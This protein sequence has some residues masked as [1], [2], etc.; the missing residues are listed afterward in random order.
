MGNRVFCSLVASWLLCGEDCTLHNCLVWLRHSCCFRICKTQDGLMTLLQHSCCLGKVGCSVLTQFCFGM[1]SVGG[2][3][4]L[5]FFICPGYHAA[6]VQGGH[7][8]MLLPAWFWCCYCAGCVG[9]QGLFL[10]QLEH[11]CY[12]GRTVTVCF[13]S[14]VMA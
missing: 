5:R 6:S 10:C 11:S 1:A 4:R 3:Q 9:S 14:L 7:G 12:V 8:I 2:R 13:P